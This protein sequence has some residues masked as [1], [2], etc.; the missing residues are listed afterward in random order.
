MWESFEFY[1]QKKMKKL[2]LKPFSYWRAYQMG[3]IDK[4]GK[5]LR[6]PETPTEKQIFNVFDRLILKIKVVFYKYIPNKGIIRHIVFR[7]FLKDGLIEALDEECQFQTRGIVTEEKFDFLEPVI[8][9]WL[10]R[11]KHLLRKDYAK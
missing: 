4:D 10:E 7:E 9:D 2:L 1:L 11:N 3:I 8:I 5:I 6:N